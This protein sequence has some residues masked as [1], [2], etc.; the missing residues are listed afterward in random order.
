L[1]DY[2]IKDK[3]AIVG[4]RETRYYKAGQSLVSEFQ[5][6]DPQQDVQIGADVEVVG[7]EDITL[8]QWRQVS[9]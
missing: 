5:L 2:S 6:G 9:Q 4:I 7:H 8:V 1:T 3:V